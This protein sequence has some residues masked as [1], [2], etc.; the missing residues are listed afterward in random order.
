MTRWTTD[1]TRG[2]SMAQVFANVGEDTA[3]RHYRLRRS[4]V[5]MLEDAAARADSMSRL[6]S[7]LLA[8]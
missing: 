2:L 3:I 1:P 7:A 5:A 8:V 4:M 6:D